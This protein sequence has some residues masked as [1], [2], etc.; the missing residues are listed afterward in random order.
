MYL[1]QNEEQGEGED[2]SAQAP[3]ASTSQQVESA[4][5]TSTG[6]TSVAA[7]GLSFVAGD[8]DLMQLLAS[9]EGGLKPGSG[10]RARGVPLPLGGAPARR[11]AA[12]LA[13]NA[14]CKALLAI[15]EREVLQQGAA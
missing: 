3:E 2:A 11:Q 12:Q 9:R 8:A 4:P 7:G 14:L 1:P 10:K 15:A 13:V 5:G 6:S